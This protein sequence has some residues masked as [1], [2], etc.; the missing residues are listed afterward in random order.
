ME[1]FKHLLNEGLPKVLDDFRL[2][3]SDDNDITTKESMEIM[4][5]ILGVQKA[6]NPKI[7]KQHLEAALIKMIQ[8]DYALAEKL[9]LET[10]NNKAKYKKIIDQYN[11]EKLMRSIDNSMRS[12]AKL[13]GSIPR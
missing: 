11:S 10:H 2:D 5:I 6:I 8:K 1:K 3:M 4:S 9:F 12:I 7:G 13:I